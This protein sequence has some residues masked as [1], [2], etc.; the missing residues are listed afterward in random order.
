MRLRLM[1]Y[2]AQTV[3]SGRQVVRF[4]PTDDAAYAGDACDDSGWLAVSLLMTGA[5]VCR[6]IMEYPGTVSGCACL[7]E[8]RRVLSA[9]NWVISATPT[10]C[11]S[12]VLLIGSSGTI[13][14]ERD[15]AYDKKTALSDSDHSDRPGTENLFALRIHGRLFKAEMA[16][17]AAF[18]RL[19][20]TTAFSAMC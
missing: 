19:H 15:A 18:S 11:I 5:G 1:N 3:L 4:S 16:R 9:L 14:D 10:S 8:C 20:P 2:T 7:K 12:T 13:G 6:S 17:R